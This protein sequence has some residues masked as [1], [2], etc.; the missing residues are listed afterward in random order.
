VERSIQH[1]GQNKGYKIGKTT[2]I[3]M[4]SYLKSSSI[5]KGMQKKLLLGLILVCGIS[6]NAVSAFAQSNKNDDYQQSISD[7]SQK[8]KTISKSLNGDKTQLKTE[9]QRL[10]KAEKELE[11][12]TNN[13]ANT[14]FELAKNEH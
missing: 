11:K 14:E 9:H 6:I 2:Q 4:F 12:I 13:L 5:F 3:L 7:I 8:I 10:F 1:R